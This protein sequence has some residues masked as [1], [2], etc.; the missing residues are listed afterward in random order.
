MQWLVMLFS[1]FQVRYGRDHFGYRLSQWETTLHCNVVS[2]LLSLYPEWSLHSQGMLSKNHCSAQNLKSTFSHVS[3]DCHDIYS[4]VI[5]N[6]TLPPIHSTHFCF[7]QDSNSLLW[8]FKINN[9]LRKKIPA[10]QGL[11]HRGPVTHVSVNKAITGSDNGLLPAPCQAII[12]T[13]AGLLPFKPLANEFNWNLNQNKAFSFKKMH[14]KMWSA[15]WQPFCLSLN[16]LHNNIHNLVE[17]APNAFRPG[18]ACMHQWT[19][20]SFFLKIQLMIYQQ[21]FRQWLGAEQAPNYY[22]N[23]H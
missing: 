11:T 9:I 3:F 1:H 12:W 19:G 20:L 22:L 17:P 8:F 23:L 14:L 21:W 5:Y 4:C 7:T 15:K 18:G 10:L 2:P 6:S 16:V 13:K